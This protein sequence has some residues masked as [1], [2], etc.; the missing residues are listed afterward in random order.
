MKHPRLAHRVW[1]GPNEPNPEYVDYDR[2]FREVNP[3]WRVI[4]WTDELVAW[5]PLIAQAAYDQAPT[6]V[7]R[8]DIVLVEMVYR[9][10]G[11]AFGFDMEPVRNVEKVIGDHDCWCTPDADGFPG[12]AFFG[13]T[14]GHPAMRAVLDRIGPR[15]AEQ[16]G[17]GQPH[18]DTGPY[19]WGDVFGRFGEQAAEHGLAILGDYR[20]AYPVRY[21][22]KHLFGIAS[23]YRRVTRNSLMVHRFA[24]TW[25]N[26]DDVRVVNDGR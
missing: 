24:H 23:A 3:G 20:T 10:G 2:R 21:W 14:P 22:E 13:A 15:I 8:A 19:L 18:I 1:L 9:F 6:Y 4:T 5:M 16:G 26:L 7:H 25:A 17:W 12:Q 11:L